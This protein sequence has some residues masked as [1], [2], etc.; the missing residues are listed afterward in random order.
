MRAVAEAAGVSRQTVH[1]H[2]GGLAGLR[3]DLA[4]DTLKRRIPRTVTQLVPID[5][6][7]HRAEAGTTRPVD[8]SVFAQALFGTASMR[9]LLGS[10]VLDRIE[11]RGVRPADQQLEAYIDLLLHGLE[12]RPDDGPEPRDRRR[13]RAARTR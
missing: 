11:R 12:R 9:V 7:R 6:L 3:R 5:W 4:D 1:Y 10:A 13:P 2:F 8:P